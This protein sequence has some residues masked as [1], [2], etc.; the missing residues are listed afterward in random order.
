[1]LNINE[2]TAANEVLADEAAGLRRKLDIAQVMS[3]TAQEAAIEVTNAAN[4]HLEHLQAVAEE[5]TEKASD[6]QVLDP[7]R[8]HPALALLWK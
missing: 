4:R 6:A 2:L 3:E 7:S 1:M 5:A 8:R